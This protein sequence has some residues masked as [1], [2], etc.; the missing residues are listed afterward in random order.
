MKRIKNILFATLAVAA[1]M[2]DAHAQMKEKRLGFRMSLTD[3]VNFSDNNQ[4]F[5]AVTIKKGQQSN[6]RVDSAITL[7]SDKRYIPRNGLNMETEFRVGSWRHKVDLNVNAGVFFQGD[8]SETIS[9]SKRFAMRAGMS[10]NYKIC[11]HIIVNGK[12][13]YSALESSFY[14]LYDSGALA[15]LHI[16]GNNIKNADH[17]PAANEEFFPTHIAL[18]TSSGINSKFKNST[19]SASVEFR[20]FFSG[21]VYMTGGLD[22]FRYN[23]GQRSIYFSGSLNDGRVNAGDHDVPQG[24]R[25]FD[26][27]DKIF[28]ISNER[29]NAFTNYCV[30]V[31][32]GM[33]LF[34][35]W[36]R[37]EYF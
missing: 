36:N 21:H 11:K 6:M 10:V 18:K 8:A 35:D 14:N 28:S 20:L 7:H 1:M 30:H 12:I 26:S 13:A 31:G 22:V 34:H 2:Q 17:T 9:S 32:V 37:R 5:D 15:F 23:L 24:F 33:S 19:F 3:V 27:H 4:P 25:D 29:S 16:T